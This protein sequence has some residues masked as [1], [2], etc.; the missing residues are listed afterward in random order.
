LIAFGAV[1]TRFNRKLARFL[2]GLTFV[3]LVLAL[4]SNLPL[5]SWL[6][7]HVPTF[8][9]FQGPTRFTIWA[10]FALCILAALAANGWRQPSA[11]QRYWLRLGVAAAVTLIAI[12]IS[13]IFVGTLAAVRTVSAGLLYLGVAALAIAFLLLRTPNRIEP[14]SPWS[15]LVLTLVSLD[16]LY[17][18]WGLNPAG[19][20][21]FY[22]TM[23]SDEAGRF[24]MPA[25]VEY[26][27]KF[28]RFFRFS[29]FETD[30]DALRVSLLPN[31]SV[32]DSQASANNFDPLLPVR[33]T[34]WIK[35]LELA[36]AETQAAMLSAMH[37]DSL[38]K[39]E[40]DV[41]TSQP[42]AALPR[43]R[44]V[45]CAISVSSSDQAL[46]LV[47]SGQVDFENSVILE[48]ADFVSC[49][50]GRGSAAITAESANSLSVAVHADRAGWL[51]LADTWFPDWHATVNGR[52]ALVYPAYGIF[53]AVSVE[54]G[55]SA[56]EFSYRPASFSVGLAVS[57][58]AWPAFFILRR[59]LDD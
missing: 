56:V 11:R 31:I 3:S 47:A 34:E 59:S 44:W 57:A 23:P 49:N 16:L 5:F 21:D 7:A 38:L 26:E 42:V 27:L 24:Y 51:V 32:L 29:S 36:D 41:V 13:A 6:F 22:R 28:N 14:R 50:E 12:S 43:A 10:V 46:Q 54:A 58:L 18:G 37:V 15:W 33:Y 4:G 25:G 53:R 48:G 19:S 39:L 45:C 55:E 2:L 1:F 20:L 52:R 35:T 30:Q 40:N 8:N 9:L 17:A